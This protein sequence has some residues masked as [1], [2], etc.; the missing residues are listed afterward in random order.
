VKNPHFKKTFYS[1]LEWSQKVE[2]D[3][4]LFSYFNK[5]DHLKSEYGHKKESLKKR[6]TN[7]QRP[8]V[9]RVPKALP[10]CDAGMSSKFLGKAWFMDTLC[11]INSGDQNDEDSETSQDDTELF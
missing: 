11:S 7:L 10:I 1:K 8:K 5:S 9:I 6:N 2:I 4:I 3:K